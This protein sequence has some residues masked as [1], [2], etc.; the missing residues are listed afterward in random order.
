MSEKMIKQLEAQGAK[1][2]EIKKPPM[3]FHV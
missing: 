1:V 2:I 3:G